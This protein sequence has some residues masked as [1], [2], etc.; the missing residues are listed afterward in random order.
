[1][2]RS[3]ATLMIDIAADVAKLVTGFKQAENVV[4]GF[5]NRM[6]SLSTQVKIA[7][8]GIAAGVVVNKIAGMASV[9]GDL[10]E[11]ADAVG[12][13]VEDFQALQTAMQQAGVSSE[14]TGAMMARAANLF[15][16]A[17]E[18]DKASIERLR[19]LGV[20][21]LDAK[22]N[23]LEFSD[24][25][26]TLAK[27]ISSIEDPMKKVT[28][29]R[30]VFGREGA[31]MIP[32]LTKL[33]EGFNGLREQTAL[34]VLSPTAVGNFDAFFDRLIVLQKFLSTQFLETLN[35]VFSSPGAREGLSALDKQIVSLA[36]TLKRI[37]QSDFG[38]I[39]GGWFEQAL[40]PLNLFLAQLNIILNIMGKLPNLLSQAGESLTAWAREAAGTV[41]QAMAIGP[42]DEAKAKKFAEE[43]R[44]IA[45]A[46]R[47]AAQ[48]LALN[49][50]LGAPNEPPP[51]TGKDFG[52]KPRSGVGLPGIKADADKLKE[53]LKALKTEFDA[54]QAQIGELLATS[55]EPTK[56]AARMA[57]MGHDIAMQV[58]KLTEQ[59]KGAG[60]D[61]IRKWVT[62]TEEAKVKLA[63]LQDVIK[64]AEDVRRQFGDGTRELAEF[65]GD[66]NKALEKGLINQEQ[67]TAAMA[68]ATQQ[69]E[70]QALS[71]QRFKEGVEG[72]AAGFEFAATQWMQAQS[73][74]NTGQQAWNVFIDALNE[75]FDAL[76]GKSQKTF[77]EIAGD[78]ALMLAKMAMQAAA[79]QIFSS[80]LGSFGGALGA[81]GMGPPTPGSGI[82]GWLGGMFMGGMRAGGGPVLPGRAY[83][84]GERGPETFVPTAAGN[85]MPNA[86][87]N[88]VVGDINITTGPGG[89]GTTSSAS[90]AMEFGRRVRSAVMDVIQNEQR[91]GGVLYAR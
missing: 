61:E 26:V 89:S 41:A 72:L 84:V 67:Y 37:S 21:I 58:N 36:E 13:A 42:E 54:T 23:V 43:Q 78:F 46:N 12:L 77:G 20:G 28:A 3:A 85:I 62:A 27:A 19:D 38:T 82:L 30:A 64:T 8:A 63:E 29:A 71:S 57:K 40:K 49:R 91:P 15:G 76:L 31:A 32:T 79:S 80:V 18:G 83:T 45:E 59:T 48:Q 56:D 17:L 70:L 24:N 35:S 90:D 22:G 60:A 88:I 9:A 47:A 51:V 2:A 55:Q 25:L 86:G 81:G 87:S 7:V 75:G 16:Q 69:Q 50:Q 44:A 10:G 74:F 34:G 65:Q 33:A 14:R 68:N 4:Q 6:K 73:T 53:I 39:M 66:L 52:I 1:M 5:G 11:Q